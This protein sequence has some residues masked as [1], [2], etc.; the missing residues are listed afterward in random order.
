MCDG[1]PRN[2][3]GNAFAGSD[4][5]CRPRHWSALTGFPS[6]RCWSQARCLL[7]YARRLDRA[8]SRRR[9][10]RCP[11]DRARQPRAHLDRRRGAF[12]SA[13]LDYSDATEIRI[14]HPNTPFSRLGQRGAAPHRHRPAPAH[15]ARANSR[16]PRRCRAGHGHVWPENAVPVLL[17]R[18]PMCWPQ[19]GAP[20]LRLASHRRLERGE[21]APGGPVN[22]L[23]V[24]Y[25]SLYIVDDRARSSRPMT[26]ITSCPSANMC[27]CAIC[28][29]AS[30]CA[31]SSSSGQFRGRA[32]PRTIAYGRAP[33]SPL[34]CYEVIFAGN[35]VAR[36]DRHG[37]STSPMTLVRFFSRAP[38]AFPAGAPARHRAGAPRCP[39]G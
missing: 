28:W 20:C 3:I 2:L 12:S 33:V 10:A 29:A 21:P 7:R 15:V 26:S 32:G 11:G 39:L 23:S 30:G 17:G 16:A 31:S 22:R 14:V 35:V 1:L 13:D 19:S 27:R 34:I 38:S 18:S 25:N 4:G 5:C 6:S 24:F 8:A 9:S 36:R 37:S